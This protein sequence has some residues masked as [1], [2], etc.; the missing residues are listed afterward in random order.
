MRT[1]CTG[2]R[3]L[4]AASGSTTFATTKAKEARELRHVAFSADERVPQRSPAP[5]E[6]AIGAEDLQTD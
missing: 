6:R 4:L 5:D 1:N 3:C 2:I